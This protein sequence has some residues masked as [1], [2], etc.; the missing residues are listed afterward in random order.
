MGALNKVPLF[1]VTRICNT[2]SWFIRYLSD[3]LNIFY[4]NLWNLSSN[5]RA[6]PS[7]MSDVS[8]VFHLHWFH[9]LSILQYDQIAVYHSDITLIFGGCCC[10]LAAVTPVKYECDLK[11]LTCKIINVL[12]E[13]D[14][15]SFSDPHPWVQVTHQ[16]KQISQLCVHRVVR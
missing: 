14:W 9:I 2:F 1:L 10:S 3:G 8:D 13:K 11:H 7:E 5:I 4:L 15:W 16:S 12:K 6:P